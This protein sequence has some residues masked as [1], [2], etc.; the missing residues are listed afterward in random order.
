MNAGDWEKGLARLRGSKKLGLDEADTA[1]CVQNGPD[2]TS[3]HPD[4]MGDTPPEE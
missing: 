2:S 1:G 3:I 4:F